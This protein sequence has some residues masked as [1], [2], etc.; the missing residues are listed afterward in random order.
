MRQV[1][2]VATKLTFAI[3]VT[4]DPT[5]TYEINMIVFSGKKAY[6]A[7]QNVPVNTPITDDAYWIETG[8]QDVTSMKEKLDELDDAVGDIQDGVA[9]LSTDVS[10]N[11]SNISSLTSDLV[12][13]TSNLNAL[14][15][16]IENIMISLYMPP[17]QS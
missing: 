3:P 14:T 10:N 1:N 12:L 4:H 16:S 7:I 8:V 13:V 9:D 15:Q 5:R 11:T 6:T 17:S 2:K